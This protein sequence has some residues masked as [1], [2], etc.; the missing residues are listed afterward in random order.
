MH[1][2]KIADLRDL[3]SDSNGC[4][5]I[6][7]SFVSLLQSEKDILN[8]WLCTNQDKDKLALTLYENRNKPL[9]GLIIGVKDVIATQEFPTKMGAGLNWD[10]PNMGFDA[11]IVSEARNLGVVIGGKVKSSEF[12]V[13]RETDVINPHY[14]GR[15]SGTSSSGS[16]AAVANGSVSIAL[17]TQTAGSIARP[18]SY[19]S[20]LAMKPSFGD[21]PR[22]G[23][24]KTTD[25]FDTVGL[26]GKSLNHI[27]EY[28]M[29]TR[30]KGLNHP[31]LEK[32]RSILE[33]N[34]VIFA[35]GNNYDRASDSLRNQAKKVVLQHCGSALDARFP[36]ELFRIR[37]IHSNIYKANL[38]YYFQDDIKTNK[39]SGELKDFIGKEKYINRSDL[40]E[41]LAQLEEW[42]VEFNNLVGNALIV[43]LA[44][45]SSAPFKDP[46]Y[47]YDM[48]LLITAAGYSQIVVPDLITDQ[49]GKNV[50]ISFSARKGLDQSLINYLR[51]TLFL[52]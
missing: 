43:S 2:S 31:I 48:N 20:V 3:S 4:R 25:E 38:S 45:N 29:Q 22:T 18:A 19:C 24:L 52:E 37:E 40:S 17:A 51:E 12:A 14:K 36:T 44:A 50:S 49:N 35:V 1:L 21:Y 28:Y 23:I 26:F 5:L 27:S 34:E 11:R 33:F 9:S 6:A 41:Y 39:V 47:D 10:N 7:D 15:T 32:R 13:H 42:R 30:L 46:A 16:A 8:P